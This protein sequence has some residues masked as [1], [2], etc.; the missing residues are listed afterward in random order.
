MNRKLVALV[1]L[2]CLTVFAVCAPF[3]LAVEHFEK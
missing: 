2:L 1:I 3:W